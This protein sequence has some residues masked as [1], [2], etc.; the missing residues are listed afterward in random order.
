MDTLVAHLAAHQFKA[1]FIERLGWDRAQGCLLV[2]V[3]GHEF[4]FET[5]AH[6]RGLAVM[7]C[8]ADRYTMF[9]RRRL[10]LLQKQ[11]LKQAHEHI[12][13]YRCEDPRKQ[14]WQWAVHLP[15]GRR[16]R[17][18]EHPFFSDSPPAA[19]LQRL[20][21]LRFTLQEE[22]RVTLVD[23]LARV[24]AALDTEADLNLFVR[25]PV[26]AEQSDQLAMAMREGG[27]AAFHEFV[28]F[29]R[30]LAKW[31]TKRLRRWPGL[32][33]EDAEQI[34]ML[35]VINAARKFK[36]E[37]GYQFSTYATTAIKRRC[38]RHGPDE[39][40]LIRVP[41]PVYWPNWNKQL[42]SERLEVRRGPGRG[43]VFIDWLRARDAK[44]RYTW[45]RFHAVTRIESI[46]D[47]AGTARKGARQ[48][49]DSASG[50]CEQV[51][52][53]E[54]LSVID[55][56]LASLPAGDARIIRLRYGLD[57]EAY[58]LEEVGS[59][60]G[61]TKERIR[62]RQVKAEKQLATIISDLYD[63]VV[64]TDP[65]RCDDETVS[66]KAGTD[67]VVNKY[68]AAH[69][70]VTSVVAECES[71]IGA[72]ELASLCGLSRTDRKS[73]IRSLLSD[74][75]IVQMGRGRRAVYRS[76]QPDTDHHSALN[77]QAAHAN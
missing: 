59:V 5:I 8:R 42:A 48:I 46:D 66:H 1:L 11:I 75:A 21:Q 65:D 38:H 31:A 23:A 10:R 69:D 62:Q 41:A 26:Y 3:D 54:Q 60:F 30:P 13:I 43:R 25:K 71:G 40:M 6:K 67:G 32:D 7:E 37:L 61:V 53:A 50:P 33:E 19:L 36:P 12:V 51:L 44:F 14:V 57:E 68:S 47:R 58:T 15:D 28:L 17:H 64:Q 55:R 70:T 24:R 9:N 20:A 56:A 45:P 34:G 72:V 35:G 73:A 77:G 39:G 29:H 4:R 16:L 76:A 27:L 22:E 52:R 63:E 2:G 74:G 49:P 18:R